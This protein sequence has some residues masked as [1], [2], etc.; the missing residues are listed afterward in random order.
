MRKAHVE[1]KLGPWQCDRREFLSISA[2]AAIGSLLAGGVTAHAMAE[3]RTG[4]DI[5]LKVA[6][7]SV[8]GYG[9]SVLLQGSPVVR[10]D[11]GEFSAVFQNGERSLEDRVEN[12][13]A[14]SWTGNDRAVTLRGNAH[15]ERMDAT[16]FVE[17]AYE[18]VA[19]NVVRKRIRL[20]QSDMFMMFFQV[21]NRIRPVADPA[22]FWSFDQVNCGGGTLREYFPSAGFRTHDDVSVG[23]LTDAGFRNQ[24][25]RMFRRDGKPIKPAAARIPDP[26]LYVVS[27]AADRQQGNNYVQ[28]TF[29]EELCELPTEV[30]A[31]PVRLPAAGD[32]VQKGM[33]VA[34]DGGV[35]EI[36]SGN[37]D[38][39][40]LIPFKAQAGAIYSVECEYRSNAD[41][42]VA[43]LDV[44]DDLKP[45]QNFNQFNDRIPASPHKWAVLRSTVFVPTLLGKSAALALSLP[46]AKPGAGNKLAIR[47]VELSRV[48]ADTRPYH[49]IEMDKPIERTAFLFADR[50]IPDTI[51][52]Y[53]LASELQL[54]EALGFEGGE[55][56]KALY[57]DLMMLC[58]NNG[59]ES[60]RPMLAPS[61]WYSA[62]GEMYLRDSFFALNGVHNQE[63]NQ[64]VFE[65]WAENQGED[66]A[67][68][69]L[70]EP[71]MTNLER[72]SNDSTPLWLMWALLNKRRFGITPPASKIER[73]ARYCLSTYDPKADGACVA[74]F[75]MGQLDIVS[76]PNGISTIC[77]NQGMLAVTLRVIRELQI[78]GIS[79]TISEDRIAN[80]EKLYRSYYD[81]VRG[82]ML[83][84]RNITEAI[85]F[86]ELFPEYLSLWLFDRKILTDEMMIR[87]LDRIPVMLPRAAAPYPEVGGTVRPIFIGLDNGTKGWRFFTE[88]W[89]PMASDSYAESYANHQMDGVYYN[90]G[91]WMRIEICGYIAG[92]L[93]GWK[94]AEKAIKNRMWAEINIAPDFPTSQ[95]YLATDPSH[96]FFGSHRVFAWN[97][98][99]LNALEQIGMRSAEMDPD[100][101]RLKG[102]HLRS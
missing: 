57:A 39:S 16:V 43:I 100:Y 97:A 88:H 75:V 56:E 1:K 66:G 76:Y 10:E 67:I 86:A 6:G 55:T 40:V 35:V 53:R 70:V 23:M 7:N 92:K 95:E 82:F 85:G 83:P 34:R 63:L 28:Q 58:W 15:L 89:H 61:I 96:P 8:E 47:R 46:E 38:G 78:P 69:T 4:S 73:A 93:H 50:N 44:D 11:S 26:N 19:R 90:G 14:T 94:P 2:T 37:P 99:V 21:T 18:V 59:T 17:V 36:A 60:F 62:A 33:S 12:W 3:G 52:G 87:H 91:S 84:A 64:H 25:S 31:Q 20:R 77:Q 65:L 68:N 13:K 29:G 27:S 72:K 45:L 81:P 80:A 30:T 32:W 49:R 42:S 48:P 54:A 79:N 41:V 71:E 101:K 102:S 24:W 51:R 5:S 22:K 9:V 98:F 74:Q